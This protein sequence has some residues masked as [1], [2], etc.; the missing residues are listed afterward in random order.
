MVDLRTKF[1]KEVDAY[2]KEYTAIVDATIDDFQ[3]ED[4]WTYIKTL[5]KVCLKIKG[6]CTK[7][8]KAS[9]EERFELYTIIVTDVL[10]STVLKSDRFSDEQKE[11][12]EHSIDL[13]DTT[14][15]EMFNQVLEE[16]DIDKNDF[17]SKSEFT[18]YIKDKY[19]DTCMCCCI[20]GYC[21]CG[22]KC[23]YSTQ[24]CIS[25]LCGCL[26]FPLLSCFNPRGI[27]RR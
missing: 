3:G 2:I 20:Q 25:G 17:V 26:L 5:M 18:T 7:I 21:E 12:I 6:S 13:I 23:C 27:K 4:I 22:T 1:H 24:S 16:M 9:G 15:P 8:K 10:R 14:L 19:E 11:I